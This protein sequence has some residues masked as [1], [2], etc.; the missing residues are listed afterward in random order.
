MERLT[1]TPAS[2]YQACVKT[3][4]V[5]LKIILLPSGSMGLSVASKL[6]LLHCRCGEIIHTFSFLLWW[7][8]QRLSNVFLVCV[9]GLLNEMYT[10]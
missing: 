6:T 10:P 3:S 7:A 5:I 8:P 9:I 2:V 1:V 4:H